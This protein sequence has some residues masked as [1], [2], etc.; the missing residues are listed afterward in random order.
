MATITSGTVMDARSVV[1]G[2]AP[3]GPATDGTR[4]AKRVSMSIRPLLES[5]TSRSIV[6]DGEETF[7][8]GDDDD[9]IGV[10]A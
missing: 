1:D 7:G 10:S 4:R 9:L 5:A 2:V 6:V 8:L 3:C